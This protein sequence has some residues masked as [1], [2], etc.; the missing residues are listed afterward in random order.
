MSNLSIFT[1]PPSELTRFLDQVSDLINFV[2]LDFSLIFLK[3]ILSIREGERK[4]HQFVFLLIYVFIGWFYVP[5]LG[6]EPTAL[7]YRDDALTSGATPP[8]Q[9]R[10][11]F[12]V[13]SLR[14]ENFLQSSD[15]I[16]EVKYFETF[17]I[18]QM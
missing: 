12:L 8:A 14:K 17:K 1:Y 6:I 7:L 3:H 4:K 10:H 5:W 18:D 2:V 11:L 15:R 9:T 16:M 13:M